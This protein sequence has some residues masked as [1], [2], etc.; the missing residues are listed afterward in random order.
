MDS[1][2][3]AA[4]PGQPN[5]AVRQELDR[6]RQHHAAG[7]LPEAEAICRQFLAADPALPAAWHLL[8]MIAHRL[9]KPDTAVDH[10]AKALTLDPGD[11]AAHSNLGNALKSAGKL[12]A[13]V[14]SFHQALA[15]APES[16]EVH[17]NLATAFVEG[18]KLEAGIASCRRALAL[19]PDFAEAHRHLAS[20]KI[21]AAHDDDIRAMEQAYAAPALSDT[22]R[23]HLAFGLGKA[24]EDL[25]RYETAF[26][27]FVEGNRILGERQR[28]PVGDYG[29]L[30]EAF[31]KA[32]DRAL[33]ARHLDT[34]CRDQTPIFVLGMLRSGT[35]LVEQILA[36]HPD[37]HGAGEVDSLSR[38][39]SAR[40][41]TRNSA[42]IP[43]WIGRAD[44]AAFERAG[45]E[46]IEAIRARAPQARFIT[47]KM[48]GNFKH[49]GLIKLMLPGSKVIHRRRDARDTCL[50]IF[51][52]YFTQQ[53]DYS[54]DLGDLGR[55]YG[56]YRDLMEH[57]HSVL[58]G[59]IHDVQ[60]EDLVA[61][62]A[63]QTRRLLEFCGL[64]WDDACLAFHET[65]RPVATASAGQVRR[66]IYKDSVQLWKN[67]ETQLATLFESLP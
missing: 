52:T 4:K 22:Q 31:K 43:Q 47:D 64:A 61:D 50:S 8:G 58:S 62:Q 51:K 55:Y 36:S 15:I 57:W 32:C 26:G 42:E 28:T 14:A 65:D 56:Y 10:I 29:G 17:C 40:A 63:G 48:P 21:F 46:Y 54:H 1:T 6:A 19:K 23:L 37:V 39:I 7:R 27:Y 35:T 18:G 67:Y 66:P 11:A 2:E 3:K 16:A 38:T 20:M 34:G 5:P 33:F 44:D 25:G 24:F 9:G 53:H 13:A 60:Y 30:F 49:I 45:A 41:G 59:F 12:D